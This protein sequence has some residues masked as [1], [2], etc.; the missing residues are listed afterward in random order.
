MPEVDGHALL[1]VVVEGE[2]PG[3]VG[4]RTVFLERWIRR[5]EDVRRRARLEVDHLRAVVRE[6]LAHERAGRGEADLD[7]AHAGERQRARRWGSRRERRGHRYNTPDP[8]SAVSSSIVSP[9][10]PR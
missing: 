6:V 8:R 2:H 10:S 9:S 4:A 7:D 5:A 3:A 1:A